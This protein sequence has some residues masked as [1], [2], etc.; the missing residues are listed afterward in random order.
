[1]ICGTAET[2]LQSREKTMNH[3]HTTIYLADGIKGLPFRRPEAYRLARARFAHQAGT[4]CYQF[5]GCDYGLR[6]EDE[7]NTGVRHAVVT[8]D[9]SGEGTCFTVPLSDLVPL[10]S[11]GRLGWVVLASIIVLVVI[12]VVG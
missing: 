5:V 6:A 12:V 10:G 11:G 9:P 7:R 8:R 1:M 4:K 3:P 2:R